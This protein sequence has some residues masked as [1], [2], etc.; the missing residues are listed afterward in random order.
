M[1]YQLHNKETFSLSTVIIPQGSYRVWYTTDQ[2]DTDVSVN[3]DI[4]H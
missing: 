4:L 1:F 2:G 3:V